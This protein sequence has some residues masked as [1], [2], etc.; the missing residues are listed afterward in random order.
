MRA[1]EHLARTEELLGVRRNPGCG[2][3]RPPLAPVSK[4]CHGKSL[5]T[6]GVPAFPAETPSIQG[7]GRLGLVLSGAA[8][9][10]PTE[11]AAGAEAGSLF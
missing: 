11:P 3:P 8:Q 6:S 10:L 4:C 1:G 7:A 5:V 2:G 9:A